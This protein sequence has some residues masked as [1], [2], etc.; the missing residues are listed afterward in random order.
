MKNQT[1]TYFQ[2]LL[3]EHKFGKIKILLFLLG[4][5]QFIIFTDDVFNE[6]YYGYMPIWPLI[7]TYIAM[8]GFTIAI[9]YQP[10]NIYKKLVRLDFFVC[11]K[12]KI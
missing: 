7:F 8:Y 6:W 4:V 11:V 5:L 9:A 2:W 12:S 3:K 10:F 1:P